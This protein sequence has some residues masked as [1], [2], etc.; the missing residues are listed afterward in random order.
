LYELTEQATFI[1]DGE[2]VELSII[3]AMWRRDSNSDLCPENKDGKQ[4]YG[5]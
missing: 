3:W 5:E 2:A 4:D 1:G